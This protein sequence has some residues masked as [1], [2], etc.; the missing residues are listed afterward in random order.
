MS[1]HDAPSAIATQIE[2]LIRLLDA[3]EA[4]PGA[5]A[6]RADSYDLLRSPAATTVVDVGCGTGRAAGELTQRGV[7]AVGVDV[8]EHMI[9]V[10]RD[11]WPDAEFRCAS[12]TAL[13]LADASVHGYRA[14]KVFHEIGDP[15]AAVAEARRVLVPGGRIVLLGQ[16]WDAFVV[17]SDLP[18]LT[19][20]IVAARARTITN[21]RIARSY[22]NLLLD[23]GFTETTLE[24]RTAVFTDDLMVPML[25]GLA[26]TAHT[27]DAITRDQADR[28]IAEQTDRGRAGR[29]MF[30]MPVYVAAATAPTD[31]KP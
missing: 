1:T 4:L 10:A 21:P 18:G 7:R 2:P 12:A 28:W 9:T 16:D 30:A 8:S 31:P 6:L 11:R 5:A 20:T 25:A 13:P 29:L 14:D 17:D 26:E 3:T 27:L 23:N 15:A 22:R 24:V 19:R